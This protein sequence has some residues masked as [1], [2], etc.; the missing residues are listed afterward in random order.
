MFGT[1]KASTTAH[2]SDFKGTGSPLLSANLS[3]ASKSSWII[4]S[5]ASDHMTGNKELFS[6]YT[7]TPTARF[8]TTAAG[9][10]SLVSGFGT[11]TIDDSL[12][13][14]NVLFVPDLACNIISVSQLSNTSQCSV[15]FD[16]SRCILQALNSKMTIGS[17]SLQSGLY[18]I[19]RKHNPFPNCSFSHLGHND[20]VL[21]WH[22]RLGHP[23]FRYLAKLYPAL[24]INKKPDLF[25]CPVC[26]LAKHTKASYKPSSYKSSHPFHLIHSDGGLSRHLD[27]NSVEIK[28]S[29]ASCH[30]QIKSLI[31][32]IKIKD[33][34][35]LQLTEEQESKNEKNR[36]PEGCAWRRAAPWDGRLLA[37]LV[38][39]V[40]DMWS[41]LG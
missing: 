18:I 17:A 12:V 25:T 34:H 20:E 10:H 23:S 7:P 22:F 6:S 35:F 8:I 1:L 30:Q 9:S 39:Q 28:D 27:V 32:P 24:F 11:V 15:I 21:L 19:S 31:S 29:S 38:G 16:G 37:L 4:D 26:P 5:G 14:H 36:R 40:S 3:A 2:T 13:L 33:W 41:L